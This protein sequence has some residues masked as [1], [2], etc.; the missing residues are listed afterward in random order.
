MRL[1]VRWEPVSS[2]EGWGA[3]VRAV[4]I[5]GG[6]AVGVRAGGWGMGWL[7]VERLRRIALTLSAE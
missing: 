2:G 6:I 7:F 4:G 5:V 1:R 3:C